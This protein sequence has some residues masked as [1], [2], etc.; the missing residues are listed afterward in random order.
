MFLEG[1]HTFDDNEFVV[2]DGA[3]LSFPLHLHRS[4]EVFLQQEGESELTVDG[5]RYCLKAGQG[6]LIFPYQCHA[7]HGGRGDRHRL[8]L[9][10]PS[11]VAD[12]YGKGDR[13]P[14]DPIFCMNA[15]EISPPKGRLQAKAMAYLL[16]A[17]FDE[18]RSYQER[19]TPFS[20]HAFLPLLLY[21]S[22]NYRKKHLLRDAVKL[23]GYDYAYMSKLFKKSV[24]LS[25]NSYVNLLRV[26]EAGRLLRGTAKSVTEVADECGFA[27]LRAFHRR[28]TEHFG[29]SPTCYRKGE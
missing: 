26:Q 10:S 12:F 18:G 7:Y 24:G 3:D 16:C 5:R 28:F 14:A 15:E 17:V 11:L 29:L 13:L 25:Y 1:D 2:S 8:C 22:E 23:S 27:S 6:V 21:A 20:E 4:F 9:F 19:K